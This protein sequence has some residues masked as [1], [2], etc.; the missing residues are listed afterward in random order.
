[1][2]KELNEA[3]YEAVKQ[4]SHPL[5]VLSGAGT[6]KTRIIT[7][8][9]AYLAKEL[10]IPLH[11]I[12]S[13]TFTNK[14]AN[15]MRERTFQILK[16]QKYHFEDRYR[17]MF[18]S[19]FHS[20]CVKI[21]RQHAHFLGYT[22]EF[23]I[24]DENDKNRFIKDLIKMNH[25]ET[26]GKVSKIKFFLE[27][28][29]NDF[30]TATDILF[31][32]EVEA[33]PYFIEFAKF[34][35]LY[36][37]GL[38]SYN[39]MDFDDLIINVI[40]LFYK[41]PSIHEFWRQ[42][43]L[44]ILVDEFQDTNKIQFLLLKMLI[45][46]SGKNLTMVGD[47]DQSIYSFRGA[48]IGNILNLN[49]EFPLLKTVRVEE[50]YRST[51]DILGIANHVIH[52]NKNRLGKT[53][54]THNKDTIKPL[55]YYAYD[56]HD[57]TFFVIEKIKEFLQEKKEQ[58]IAI[59]YRTNAQSRIFEAELTKSKIP[60]IL[61]GGK[62]FYE[63][64]EIKDLISYLK[65][66]ANPKDDISLKRIL[67]IPQRGVGEVTFSKIQ[68]YSQKMGLSTFEVL[69]E[70]ELFSKESKIKMATL[71]ALKDFKE[72]L[73]QLKDLS[74]KEPKLVLGKLIETTEYMKYIDEYENAF[75]RRLNIEELLRFYES[76]FNEKGN[77]FQDFIE[78][79]ELQDSSDTT[80]IPKKAQVT[81]TT[82]HGC[83]GLEFD[84]VFIVGLVEEVFPH[85]LSIETIEE[86]EEERRL[87]YVAVTR[88]KKYLF[89]SS[90]QKMFINGSVGYC[91]ESRFLKEMPQD[92]LQIKKSSQKD[93]ADTWFTKYL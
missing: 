39:L 50:N 89:F 77:E 33:D 73:D 72:L 48:S 6:G 14:A 75:N 91:F 10:K 81:L 2:I 74:L 9:I 85:Y 12:L 76:F 83:K 34:Y 69:G 86:L 90:P 38:F 53:L 45:K 78:K 13:L 28:F 23:S 17:N 62:R 42:Q 29:K 18:I 31:K 40:K 70:I 57:E 20:N 15:E 44:Y 87:F 82:I 79:V 25:L 7:Y 56:D 3:Q 16:K 19:T 92:L 63:R 21:L 37:K 64:M 54:F 11:R 58:K 55:V 1:M 41:E 93:G 71:K 30:Q 65:V 36:E 5:L 47:D 49:K 61:L 35:E 27:H 80:E 8:K 51:P 4:T 22:K 24:L 46:E 66:I 88:A 43:F 60:Y 84:V 52:N 59:I 26:L 68:N 32:G 67:N